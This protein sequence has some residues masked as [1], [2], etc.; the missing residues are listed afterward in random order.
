MIRISTHILQKIPRSLC[1]FFVCPK[2]VGL[3]IGVGLLLLPHTAVA[4]LGPY[5][6]ITDFTGTVIVRSQVSPPSGEW[7][8]VKELNYPLFKGDEIKTDTG[9]VEITFVSDGSI[10]SLEEETEISLDEVP[11][12]RIILGV[13]SEEFIRRT[14]QV[15]RG[16]LSGTIKERKDVITEFETP[17]VVAGVRGTELTFSRDPTTGRIRVSSPEGSVDI[18][19][20]DGKTLIP[21]TDGEVEVSVD[22]DTG[23][24]CGT[25][26]SGDHELKT[27]AGLIA[28]LDE[29]KGICV[30]VDFDAFCNDVY[31]IA[32]RINFRV[33]ENRVTIDEDECFGSLLDP[34][35]QTVDLN[36]PCHEIEVNG[37]PVPAPERPEGE[38]CDC[39]SCRAEAGFEVPEPPDIPDYKPPLS[40]SPST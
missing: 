5:A 36:N 11:K 15:V 14:I 29:R 40:G 21:L 32:G 37:V 1:S 16:T 2:R 38:E 22:S 35:T 8:Q 34:E 12:Q 24:V 23:L 17:T 20:T 9:T 10:I 31:A 27:G 3:L 33:G 28:E 7:R 19:T 18:Y 26:L 6:T 39:S 30:H 13:L 25:S 4:Q